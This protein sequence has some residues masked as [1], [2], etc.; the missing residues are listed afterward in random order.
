MPTCRKARDMRLS[1]ASPSS[2]RLSAASPSKTGSALLMVLWLTAALS[3]VGLA[4]ANN[5]RGETE[6]TETNV[7]DTRAYFIARGSIERAALHILWGRQYRAD[8]GSPIYY[9]NGNPS[10]ELAFPA[11]EVHVDVIPESSRL[12][13]NGSRPEDIL[14]LLLALGTPEDRATEIYGG[15]PRLAHIRRPAA[16]QPVRFVLFEPV[17]VFCGASRVFSGERGIA[18]GQR[19]DGRTLLRIFTQ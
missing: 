17:S 6:R 12:S 11:A 4:V 15:H 1:A 13:L 5:V 7:D 10:M 9:V 18:A 14:R 3:A 2:M 16:P 19:D 8:D